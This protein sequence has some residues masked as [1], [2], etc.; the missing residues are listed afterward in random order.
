MKT[1]NQTDTGTQGEFVSESQAET[2]IDRRI[3]RKTLTMATIGAAPER[4]KTKQQTVML[5][6][7]AGEARG[8]ARECSA[9]E[10]KKPEDQREYFL[11]L[12]GQFEADVYDDDGEI[13]SFAGGQCYLPTGFHEAVL[14]ELTRSIE[15]SGDQGRARFNLEFAAQPRPNPAGYGYVARNLNRIVV[16]DN[17]MLAIM[18]RQGEE[19][20]KSPDLPLLT[21]RREPA[22]KQLA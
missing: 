20:R 9:E 2:A 17:D 6:R 14:T 19:A 13:L 21:G 8:T 7:I 4:A 16:D 3:H 5:C 1:D 12:V 22:Q 11:A 18:R 10:M 15:A